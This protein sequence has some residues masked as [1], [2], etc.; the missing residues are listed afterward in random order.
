MLQVEVAAG[1][2][3][4]HTDRDLKCKFAGEFHNCGERIFIF[5][6]WF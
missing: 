2:G 6:S 3:I 5:G 4:V 1:L